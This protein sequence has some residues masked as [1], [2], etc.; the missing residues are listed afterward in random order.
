[1]AIIYVSNA[2]TNGYAVGNDANSGLT[3]ALAK[4]TFDGAKAVAA[5]GD[6]LMFNDGV[7]T[8]A[9]AFSLTTA[10]NLDC[11][12]LRG[13]TLRCT[14][15]GTRGFFLNHP[16]G[17]TVTIGALVFDDMGLSQNAFE[18][19][20]GVTLKVTKFKGS[21]FTGGVQYG[22]R[23]DGNTGTVME[24]VKFGSTTATL[25]GGG[26]NTLGPAAFVDLI[27]PE[28][29]TTNANSALFIYGTPAT[30]A[31][32]R[33]KDAFGGVSK[34]GMP[35]TAINVASVN[36]TYDGQVDAMTQRIV[37]VLPAAAPISSLL[38][39]R[40]L[41]GSVMQ[42]PVIRRFRGRLHPTNGYGI[43]IGSDGSGGAEDNLIPGGIVTE[44][45]LTGGGGSGHGIMFGSMSGGSASHNKLRNWGISMLSKLQ[46]TGADF[47][48]NDQE[49]NV[50]NT[51]GYNESKGSGGVRGAAWAFNNIRIRPGFE[52]SVLY[53]QNDPTIPTANARAT[54]VSNN[55]FVHPG[56][57]VPKIFSVKNDGSICNF[58]AFNNYLVAGTLGAASFQ[59]QANFYGSTA[60]WGAAYEPTV[61][62][63]SPVAQDIRFWKYSYLPLRMMAFRNQPVL[64]NI[65]PVSGF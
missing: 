42:P 52:N 53:V 56:A 12:T 51:D 2:A 20:A 34:P 9:G 5:P 35:V 3:K 62:E 37:E 60:A 39:V 23:T 10:V 49:Q 6:T 32:V 54:W 19:N 48:S 40:A 7:F 36:F 33:V 59:Y 13:A 63:W 24:D 29:A 61:T 21:E 14:T 45:D 26:F 11:E 43:R 57:T 64:H 25:A 65:F 38:T 16:D 31:Y 58:I 50:N 18:I 30:P 8:R 55:T 28:L 44:C 27:R 17:T 22:F 47:Y 46:P 41:P 1:M 15:A 4:L